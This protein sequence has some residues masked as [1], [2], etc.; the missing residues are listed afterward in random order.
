MAMFP[1]RGFRA[2]GLGLALSLS[3]PL[4]QLSADD[5]APKLAGTW[6]WEWKDA[7]GVTHH[8]VLEVE[9]EGKDLVA[10]ERFDDQESVKVN[11]LKREGKRVRF[12][13]LRGERTA[14]Y[15]GEFSGDGTIDGKVSVAGADN[16]ANQFGWTA[17]RKPVAPK[18]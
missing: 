1:T 10:R 9:G 16:Q 3:L 4:P 11:D 7:Q 5:P 18:R 15:D 2:M 8:H 12:S 6:T 14:S 13:V 17:K